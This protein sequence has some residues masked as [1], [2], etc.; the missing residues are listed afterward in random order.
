[1]AE[2]PPAELPAMGEVPAMAEMPSEPLPAD[3]ELVGGEVPLAQ[4]PVPG[5]P[6]AL[7]RA[8]AG[9]EL[10]AAAPADPKKTMMAAKAGPQPTMLA[11][12]GAPAMPTM[13]ARPTPARPT[14]IA[15]QEAMAT[16]VAESPDPMPL[17][18]GK[19]Q[20]K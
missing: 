7:S 16:K 17:P 10:V 5:G 15:P 3:A 12:K 11:R 8:G 18:T 9:E 14:M 4:P 6:S 2:P 20:K 19:T 13:L 1:M